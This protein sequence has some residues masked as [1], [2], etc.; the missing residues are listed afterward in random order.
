M[1]GAGA[2]ST[3]RR[4]AAVRPWKSKRAPGPA[5]VGFARRAAKMRSS[6]AN[7]SGNG[8]DGSPNRRLGRPSCSTRSSRSSRSS[9]GSRQIR[10]KGWA[11]NHAGTTG[12]RSSRPGSSSSSAERGGSIRL[13]RPMGAGFAVSR[14][15][16]F[17]RGI[18]RVAMARGGNFR[19]G[20][21]AR[22]ASA[23]PRGAGAGKPP[24][25]RLRGRCGQ[26]PVWMSFRIRETRLTVATTDS[27]RAH[28][29]RLRAREM[30][31]VSLRYALSP[32][33]SLQR[34]P[35]TTG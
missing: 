28:P 34:S 15:G 1:T 5:V 13:S 11:N 12:T 17:E 3:S 35:P 32:Q 33:R 20:R 26:R 29:T 10:L 18:N 22:N 16:I 7:G 2:R 24:Q 25:R 27:T 14:C 8:V 31:I 21:R 9:G 30:Q 23:R 4:M 6:S 19:A